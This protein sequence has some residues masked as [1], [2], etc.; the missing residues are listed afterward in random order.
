MNGHPPSY[1][2][3]SAEECCQVHFGWDLQTCRK[4]SLGPPKWYPMEDGG[5][6]SN[7]GNYPK[8]MKRYGDYLFDTLDECCDYHFDWNT[9]ACKNPPSAPDPCSE[10]YR[11][12]QP[13]GYNEDFVMESETGYYPACKY[14]ILSWIIFAPSSTYTHSFV[15]GFLTRS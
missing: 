6:C 5:G 1:L 9:E 10:I 15:P 13:F 14:L 4:K 11:Y 8:Y 7:D 3:L 12:Y 2:H